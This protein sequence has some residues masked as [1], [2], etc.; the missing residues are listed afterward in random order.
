MKYVTL[1]KRGR[2]VNIPR[3][4]VVYMLMKGWNFLK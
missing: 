1:V 3:K 4:F 2:E